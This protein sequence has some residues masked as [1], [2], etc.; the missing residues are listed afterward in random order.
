MESTKEERVRDS[1]ITQNGL[2]EGSYVPL[3]EREEPKW[4]AEGN[5][6]GEEGTVNTILLGCTRG[7][8]GFPEQQGGQCGLS[9]GGGLNSQR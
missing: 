2:G 5:T 4:T 1:A 7:P 6:F 9:R 3:K 8:T